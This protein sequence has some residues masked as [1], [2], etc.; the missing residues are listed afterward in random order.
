MAIFVIVINIYKKKNYTCKYEIF[1]K[2][3]LHSTRTVLAIVNP[4][5]DIICILHII[6]TFY[7]NYGLQTN[8]RM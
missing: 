5:R 7:P 8:F 6:T 4:T 3:H 1:F 2:E